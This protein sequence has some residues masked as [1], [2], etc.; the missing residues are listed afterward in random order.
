MLNGNIIHTKFSPLAVALPHKLSQAL[1]SETSEINKL[2]LYRLTPSIPNV[3]TSSVRN[4]HIIFANAFLLLKK[5]E[6]G[7]MHNFV[8]YT[9]SECIRC[10]PRICCCNFRLSCVFCLCGL[11]FVKY[12]F[13]QPKH[14]P[15]ENAHLAHCN[16]NCFSPNVK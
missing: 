12:I 10:V 7:T 8:W 5:K 9:Q 13:I 3:Y 11:C 1:L 2:T 14:F 15:Y 6:C 16:N 4:P